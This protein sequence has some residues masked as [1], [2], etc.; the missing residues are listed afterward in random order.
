MVINP[1]YFDEIQQWYVIFLPRS[2]PRSCWWHWLVRDEFAHCWL[3]REIGPRQMMVVEQ[4]DWGIA[5][6]II[7]R[8]L[9]E[10]LLEQGR[11]ATAILGYTADYRRQTQPRRRVIYTCVNTVKAVLGLYHCAEVQ[12]PYG[13][14]KLMLRYAAT[15]V[16]KPFVPFVHA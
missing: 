12:T 1:I 7:D 3:A 2:A 8:P 6:Q 5:V 13:L 11:I 4:N 9:D 16:V 14:Y 10:Y 15:T